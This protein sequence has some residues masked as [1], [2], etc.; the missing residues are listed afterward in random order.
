[1]A[2]LAEE[3]ISGPRP[4]RYKSQTKEQE[5]GSGQSS[6]GV[7]KWAGLGVWQ[8]GGAGPGGWRGEEREQA[9]R[10]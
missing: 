1:M 9:N 3:E 4:G 10:R 2:V 7:T 5:A 6:D 8:G